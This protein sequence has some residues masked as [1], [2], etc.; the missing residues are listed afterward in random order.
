MDAYDNMLRS[1]WSASPIWRQIATDI[2]NDLAAVGEINLADVLPVALLKGLPDE[3]RGDSIGFCASIAEALLRN[4]V[5]TS[6]LMH[7]VMTVHNIA[8]KMIPCAACR[9]ARS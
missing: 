1:E 4:N 9:A 3:Q 6:W 8:C 7:E 5:F 2:G